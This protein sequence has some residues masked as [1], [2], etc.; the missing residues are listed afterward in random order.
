LK[1]ARMG[2]P[3]VGQGRRKGEA[4]PQKEAI[5]AAVRDKNYTLAACNIKARDKARSVIGLDI[6]YCV[7]KVKSNGML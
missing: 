3:G 7:T 5:P 1:E 4:T 6:A 2:Q